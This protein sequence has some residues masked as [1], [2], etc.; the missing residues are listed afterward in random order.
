M[1]SKIRRNADRRRNQA[2]LTLLELL[3]VITIL[4]VLTVAVGTV[5]LRYLGRSKADA[6]LLQINQIEAGLDLYKLDVGR[7]PT[8]QEGLGVLIEAPA[9]VDRWRGPYV[10][11]AAAIVDPWGAEFL[12][13]FPGRELD[14][15]LYS[16]GADGVA[17]GED[18][19]A[20]VERT[21]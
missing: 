8:S 21:R 19:A 15:D 10:G 16:F 14:Y 1:K 6:A 11:K 20:D 9:G 2:G 7:Y 18:D 3:V 4:V 17:G 13:E 5:A 12:Y